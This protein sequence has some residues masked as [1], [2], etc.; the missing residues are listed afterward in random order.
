MAQRP[1]LAALYLR[2]NLNN[3]FWPFRITRTHKT[4]R[5]NSGSVDNF[6]LTKL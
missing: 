4:Q 1:L 2:K 5:W 6:F 3:F